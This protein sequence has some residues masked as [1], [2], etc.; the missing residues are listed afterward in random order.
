MDWSVVRRLWEK[1]TSNNVGSTGQPLKAALLINYDPTGPSR[2]VST[3]A[4]QD[5]I[6]ADPMEISQFINFVRRNKLQ[7]ESF[8]IGPNQYLVTSIHESWFCARSMNSSKQAGEGCI[9]MQTSAFLL[10]GLYDGSIGPASSAMMAVDQ[11]AGKL[12]RRN[13]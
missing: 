9:V 12:G 8:F 5:G 13:Y 1:W 4:E 10:V 11:F 7:T 3:V 6:K 2:L